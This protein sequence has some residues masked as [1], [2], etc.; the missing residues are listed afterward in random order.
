MCLFQIIISLSCSSPSGC[1]SRPIINARK[2]ALKTMRRSIYVSALYLYNSVRG[3]STF[4]VN[5]RYNKRL[6]DYKLT[7]VMKRVFFKNTIKLFELRVVVGLVTLAGRRG[8]QLSRLFSPLCA[9][10]L[11]LYIYSI[12]LFIIINITRF[13]LVN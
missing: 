7:I 6:I 9:S 3:L 11:Y 2:Y 1:A 13:G 5:T 4:N 10:Y 8:S 12:C